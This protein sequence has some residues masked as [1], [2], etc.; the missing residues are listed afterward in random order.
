[1]TDVILGNEAI[2]LLKVLGLT[3]QKVVSLVLEFSID[4]AMDSVW[5]VCLVTITRIGNQSEQLCIQ[6]QD[7]LS[8]LVD[9][10]GL[11]RCVR[12]TVRVAI[13]EPVTITSEVYCTHETLGKMTSALEGVAIG[14][15]VTHLEST[16]R[17]WELAE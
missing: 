7:K 3:G 1:M 17:E 8:A 6:D 10:L 14:H 16:A 2:E 12:L 5:R 4:D 11:K 13:D 15:D 9:A